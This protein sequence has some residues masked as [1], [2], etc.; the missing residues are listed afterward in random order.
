M[1]ESKCPHD[2]TIDEVGFAQTHEQ[3]FLFLHLICL[4]QYL[5]VPHAPRISDVS[6]KQKPLGENV[7]M[8]FLKT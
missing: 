2:H 8:C 4:T 6:L 5:C 7:N 3:L 1:F